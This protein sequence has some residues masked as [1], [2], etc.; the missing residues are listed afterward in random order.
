MPLEF[1]QRFLRTTLQRKFSIDS[2]ITWKEPFVSLMVQSNKLWFKSDPIGLQWVLQ[3]CIFP[4]SMFG[5]S[6]IKTCG[7][8]RFISLVFRFLLA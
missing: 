1:S 2:R 6:A 8:F 7:H 5:N 4:I 3:S